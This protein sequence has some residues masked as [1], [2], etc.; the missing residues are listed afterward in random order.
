MAISDFAQNYHDQMFP[1]YQSSFTKTDPEFIEL[2]DNFAFDNVLQESAIDQVTRF[3]LILAALIGC[4]GQ[5]EFQALL[6][7]ALRFGVTAIEIKEIIY[8]A[9]AY[10]GIGRVFPF[11]KISNLLFEQL[12][13][14]ANPLARA[15]ST[16]DNHLEKGREA[17]VAIMGDKMRNFDQSGPQH[18]QTINRWLTENCFGDYYTRQ[19][20]DYAKRELMTLCYLAAQGACESQLT[21]HAE[22]NLGLGH[23]FD[24]L[25]DA[26]TQLVPYIGY[27]RV[28]NAIVCLEKANATFLNSEVN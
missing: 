25:V 24:Y 9:V 4:Q 2:F 6:P 1:N 7:A 11:L 28:L 20:L 17:L 23:S 27:P 5:D 22:T 10:L 21:S 8:Q 18:R 12:G 15:T 14:E 16:P 3:Q 13:I 26:M 19:G